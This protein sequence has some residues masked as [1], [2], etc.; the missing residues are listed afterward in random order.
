VIYRAAI[1]GAAGA[2]FSPDDI[3]GLQ[4]W[5][6]ASDESTITESSGSVSQWDDKSGNGNHVSQ[7][8]AADQPTT[9]VNTLNGLN[10]ISWN[11]DVLA[12]TSLD[13]V[14]PLTTFVVVNG[15][16][17]GNYVF[18]SDEDNGGTNRLS[19]FKDASTGK[20]AYFATS[21]GVVGNLAATSGSVVQTVEW[22]GSSSSM[23]QNGS[24]DV[25]GATGAAGTDG[26]RV[27]RRHDSSFFWVG[28]IAEIL[29]YDSALSTTD[30]EALEVY[31]AAK[32]G[33]TLS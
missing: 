13:L 20:F 30:R 10:V 21:S 8:T 23:W 32:W 3:A 33:I 19:L 12:N 27:G 11:N 5:L 26:F 15:G 7:G 24:L 22:N 1:L 2:S 9:G 16:S 31:L 25:A 29:V 14:Q 28:D 17:A 4:L 6:D 18:D